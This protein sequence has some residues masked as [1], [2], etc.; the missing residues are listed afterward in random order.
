MNYGNDTSRVLLSR[1]L[2][3]GKSERIVQIHSKQFFKKLTLWLMASNCNHSHLVVL[4]KTGRGHLT[5]QL[6]GV[7]VYIYQLLNRNR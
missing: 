6:W 5:G 4:Q 1:K 7:L 3:A 2:D